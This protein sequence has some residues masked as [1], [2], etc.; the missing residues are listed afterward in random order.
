MEYEM[1]VSKIKTI[2][3][4]IKND[5]PINLLVF[6]NMLAKLNLHHRFSA[7]DITA[8]K[9]I[10]QKYYVHSIHPD[11]LLE[12]QALVDSMGDDRI[13]SAQQ[14][15]SHSHNVLGSFLVMRLHDQAPTIILIDAKGEPQTQHRHTDSVLL[16]ENRQLFIEIEETLAFLYQQ[17]AYPKHMQ[18]DIIFAAGNE[19]S[20]GLHQQFLSQY[21]HIYC[22]F[23]VDLGGLTIAKNLYNLLDKPMTF[24]VPDDI[25]IRLNRVVR[26]CNS[27]Y[28][29]KVLKLGKQ[30]PKLQQI[31]S[32]IAHQHKVLEQ[33]EY[34]SVK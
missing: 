17:T 10:G 14:N 12:L 31:V 8:T 6:Q 2:L 3:A 33:E 27:T 34:L 22:L 19:I 16:I 7:T 28:I 29:D 13:S 4:D 23:D 15:L 32:L 25:E 9:A 5:E 24:I 1:S 21:Q 26:K 11:L 18:M 30:Q 20:N